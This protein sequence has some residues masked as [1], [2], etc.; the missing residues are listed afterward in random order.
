MGSI[1]VATSNIGGTESSSVKLQTGSVN[2]IQGTSFSGK[3]SLMRGMHLG[4]VGSPDDH[5]DEI[6]RLHLNDAN[7]ESS[8]PLLRRGA[9]K[10]SVSISY[11]GGAMEATIGSNGQISGK[12]S[13]EKAV[14][15][16]MLSDLPKTRLYS[17]VFDEENG[18]DFRW[19]STEVSEAKEL[20]YWQSVLRPLSQE[21]ASIRS[22][23]ESWK[24]SKEDAV[25]QI[26]EIDEQLKPLNEERDDLRSDDK[27]MGDQHAKKLTAAE[28]RLDSHTRAYNDLALQVK[29]I[30][31]ENA[32]HLRRIEAAEASKKNAKRQLDDAEDIQQMELIEPDMDA[33]DGAVSRA[34]EAYNAVKRDAAPSTVRIIDAYVQ[35]VNSGSNVPPK[36]ADAIEKEREALGDE[37]KVGE[38]LD[39]LTQAKKSRDGAVRKFMDARSKKGSASKMAAAARSDIMAADKAINEA[40]TLMSRKGGE[41]SQKKEDLQNSKNQYEGSKAE[42]DDLSGGFSNNPKVA[43]LDKKIAELKSK[44]DGLLGSV[45]FEFTLNSLQMLPSEGIQL[46]EELGERILGNGKGGKIRKDL[47]TF[48]LKDKS[49]AEIR[50]LIKAE[51]DNG[52]LVDI[53]VTSDWVTQRI[54]NQLQQTRKVFNDVGTTMFEKMPNSRIKSVELDTN[55]ILVQTWDD[56]KETGL[57]GSGG[58][59]ALT[60]AAIL[61]AMRKAFTPDIPIL[62]IDGVLEKLD[63]GARN[64]LLGFLKEYAKTDGVTIVV[65]L[66][67]EKSTE[68]KVTSL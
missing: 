63:S 54:E 16:S 28:N 33:L 15:T 34:T 14:Y 9:S 52:I 58:E 26:E 22:K 68:V 36:L 30:E 7:P 67:D 31:T 53:D 13:N 44:R 25:G 37:S 64:N 47:V 38:A 35:V 51:I 45:D 59:R 10:G 55:Y 24:S 18:D 40:N 8:S 57:A 12:G 62:M 19:V 20:E 50:S 32:S 3:S 66:L 65:S 41:L 29:N 17:A 21:L 2:I 46:T 23:F 48:N 4:L 39:A 27:Q 60:A 43:A 5:R 1:E 6:E 49:P 11:E 42:V 61:I 56:G